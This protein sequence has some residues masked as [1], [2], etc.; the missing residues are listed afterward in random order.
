MSTSNQPYFQHFFRWACLLF[1]TLAASISN[2]QESDYRYRGEVFGF[3]G[4]GKTYDDEGSLGSGLNAGGGIGYR[5]HRKFG[6]EIEL[7]AHRHRREF[8]SGVVFEGNGFNAALS[9]LYYFGRA[10]GRA[11]PYLIGG[12]GVMHERNTSSFPGE[13]AFDFSGTGGAV[14][15]GAGAKIFVR[16]RFSLRPEFRVFSGNAGGLPV[17]ESPFS[18]WRFSM[19]AGYHW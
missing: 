2:A 18:I 1:L 4:V 10:T 14:N 13:S 9:G 11:Q 16:E 6:A 12:F 3:I 8:S 15:L 17:A 19:G 7:A 5:F